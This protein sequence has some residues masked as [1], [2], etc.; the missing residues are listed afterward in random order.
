MQA[1]DTFSQQYQEYLDDTYDCVDRIVLNAYCPFLQ[2]GGGFR[3][4]WRILKG[5]DDDLDNTHLM[6]FAG[7]F[8][9]RIHAYCQANDIPI[10]ESKSKERKDE[11]VHQYIPDDRTFRGI[12]CVV[13]GR[14]PAPVYEVKH[15]D[16]GGIDIRKKHPYPYIN[17]Y[18]LH[19]MDP[20]WGHLII[21]FCPHPPFNAQII[22]NGHEYV[23]CQARKQQIL[24]TKEGNCFTSFSDSP[25]L[26]RLADTMSAV[27]AEGRLAQVCESWIYSSCLCFALDIAE[28]KRSGFYYCYSVYQAEYSRNLLFIR[29]QTMETIFESVIDRTRSL[30]NMRSIKTIFGYKRRPIKKNHQ[31]KAPRLEVEV[32]RPAYNLTVFKVH[33]G[34]LTAKIYCKGD[35]VLRIETIAHNTKDLRCGKGLDRF[36]QIV[37]ALKE[38]LERFLAIV[39]SVDAAFIGA[40]T[41]ESWS[42]PSQVGAVRVGGIDLN[43]PRQR[44]VIQA[45]LALAVM[46]QGFSASQ[47]AQ[48]VRDILQLQ[49]NEY[50]VRH[51]SYDLKKLRGKQ[52]VER[53]PSSHRYQPAPEK[54]QEMAAAWGLRQKIINPLLASSEKLIPEPI[55]NHNQS[56]IDR[57]Y[58]NIQQEMQQ[59]FK[60]MNFAA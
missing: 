21:R 44:A 39:R 59:L 17:H 32:E 15:F 16:N 29:G 9:R 41:L 51:A 14:A 60:I 53:F 35:R 20:D 24:F 40:D 56:P 2:S 57:Q 7:R 52:L 46:P 42:H 11:K 5:N 26:V 1:P 18:H 50:R 36:C 25:G 12:F 8:A 38:I 55:N 10:F 58:R 13:Y 49:E 31:G 19:I 30:L 34:K 28:Q 48:L 4:W 54:V 27:G 47:L 3:Y 23:A 43:K 22:L 45:V 6:R 33:F 37:E